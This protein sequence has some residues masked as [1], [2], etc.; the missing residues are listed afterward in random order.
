MD[1]ITDLSVP[2]FWPL[3]DRKGQP[4]L[5]EAPNQSHLNVS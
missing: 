1:F 4:R 5:I 3:A 2:K